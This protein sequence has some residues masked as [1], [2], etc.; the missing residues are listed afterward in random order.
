[1][2]KN[3]NKTKNTKQKTKNNNNVMEKN[4]T[5][6]TVAGAFYFL[7]N[8]VIAVGCSIAGILVLNIALFAPTAG[9]MYITFDKFTV[10]NIDFQSFC[11]KITNFL[12]NR[13]MNKHK[14]VQHESNI[15]I[16]GYDRGIHFYDSSVSK[17]QDRIIRLCCIN[18]ELHK[19]KMH[20]D[21]TL[22]N[23]LSKHEKQLFLTVT[24][25]DI[26]CNNLYVEKK[27]TANV[28]FDEKLLDSIISNYNDAKS[29]K[30]RLK[31]KLDDPRYVAQFYENITKAELWIKR[32][33]QIFSFGATFILFPIW[34][35]SRIFF[36]IFPFIVIIDSY[37]KNR[38]P[39]IDSIQ[40][41]LTIAY[42][43]FCIGWIIAFCNVLEYYFWIHHVSVGG[44][45]SLLTING[46]NC[47]DNI[48]NK[49]Y[50]LSQGFLVRKIV[51]TCMGHDIGSIVLDYWANIDLNP[52]EK[53]KD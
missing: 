51:F 30:E 9:L 46:N 21:E 22:F 43:T 50:Q 53:E 36:F 37:N 13:P 14:S 6:Q 12:F 15:S 20:E 45:F 17:K 33:T 31:G 47:F 27:L 3:L 34:C 39:S 24:P 29:D 28:Y 8:V 52:Q 38:L 18:Y 23:F 44:Y 49:Y 1:M 40:S 16:S 11:I 32:C 26:R 5:K 2:F 25:Q 10:S 7:M 48:V 41:I 42:W 35:L 4:T 19:T